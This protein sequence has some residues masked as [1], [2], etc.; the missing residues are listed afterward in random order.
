[1]PLF[2]KLKEV[3]TSRLPIILIFLAILWGCARAPIKSPDEAMRVARKEPEVLADDLAF[4]GLADAIEANIK[5][6]RAYGD[7]VQTLKFGPFQ[8][9]KAEYIEMLEVL[10]A[11]LREDGTGH[12]FVHTLRSEFVLLE[13]YGSD[14]WGKVFVTSYFE[15]VIEGSLKRTKKFTQ[16]IYGVP[17]DMVLVKMR[18]F[19]GVLRGRLVK[20]NT[21]VDGTMSASLPMVV[22][23]WT[24]QEIDSPQ[25]PV[26][27]TA[28]VIAW[29]DPIDSFFLQIQGSGKIKLSDGRLIRVG[30]GAQNG[31]PYVAIG[32][33]LF[34]KIP[35]EKMSQ[36]KIE[37]YLRSLS[38]QEQQSLLN[39]NPSYVFFQ[40]IEGEPRT[41]FGTEV[42]PGRTIATDTRYFPKGTLGFLEYE[43]PEFATP[44]DEEPIGF[45]KST[46]FVLDQDTGGAI[47]GPHRLDLF[48]G[49]GRAAAQVSGVM[50]NPGRLYYFFPKAYLTR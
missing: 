33:Y 32:Q 35:R 18:E 3:K 8:I 36:Q 4:E 12:S 44:E 43:R 29:V 23:Y 30:Y 27:K 39:L 13:V 24:R 17:G 21:R 26:M 31:H 16:P 42:V 46:R 45:Q 47:K 5:R 1:M 49:S 7:P 34:D 15:P 28:K 37:R 9:P 20:S 19:T 22:P 25:A 14:E 6:L 48:W 50:R 40:E 2:L 41:F 10:A 11:R 38:P